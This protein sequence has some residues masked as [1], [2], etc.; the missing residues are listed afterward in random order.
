MGREQSPWR[1]VAGAHAHTTAR[2][3]PH[4]VTGAGTIEKRVQP[5]SEGFPLFLINVFDLG[6]GEWF[7]VRFTTF[8]SQ[9]LTW[10]D[11]QLLTPPAGRAERARSKA[12]HEW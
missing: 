9:Y 4:A 12:N 10:S 7:G 5:G 1:Q 11:L 3:S 6:S 8:A 2:R